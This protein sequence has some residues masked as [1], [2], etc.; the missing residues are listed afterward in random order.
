M[1]DAGRL[2]PGTGQKVGRRQSQCEGRGCHCGQR[3]CQAIQ[4]GKVK[5]ASNNADF[6][7]NKPEFP[8]S[9]TCWDVS[10]SHV[11][12]DQHGGVS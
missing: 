3:I 5:L 10:V 4:V 8:G 11:P 6:F 2:L 1:P 7:K 9:G 12:R